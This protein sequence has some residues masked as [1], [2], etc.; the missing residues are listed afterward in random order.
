MNAGDICTCVATKK[1]LL[2]HRIVGTMLA[3]LN[4]QVYSDSMFVVVFTLFGVVVC[5]RDLFV[6]L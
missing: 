2:V 6:C 1:L 3:C 4:Y 5:G